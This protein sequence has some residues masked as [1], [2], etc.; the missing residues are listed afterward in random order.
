[1]ISSP[2][3]N[4][5]RHF[6]AQFPVF[7]A[8]IWS[9][10]WSLADVQ[11]INDPKSSISWKSW[12]F[13]PVNVESDEGSMKW[14][15]DLW[16]VFELS[17]SLLSA[18]L[19]DILLACVGSVSGNKHPASNIRL[20]NST[21]PKKWRV[22]SSFGVKFRVIGRVWNFQFWP[23]GETRGLRVEFWT[24]NRQKWIEHS[25]TTR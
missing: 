1:M 25:S 24:E 20:K 17:W 12:I 18:S 3:Q 13:V 2:V 7:H 11:L 23:L 4:F 8:V 15:V 14:F 22:K 10:N 16:Q 19:K 5:R 21:R 9:W 6:G